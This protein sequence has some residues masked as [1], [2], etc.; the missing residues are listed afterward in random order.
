M[1]SQRSS[2]KGARSPGSKTGGSK[3]PVSKAPSQRQLRVGEELRHALARI[4]ARDE[5]RD[6]VLVG[7][8]LT[9]TEVRVSPDLKNAT[10]FVVPLGGDG[11]REVLKVLNRAG[12]F[13][14]SQMSREVDL[15]HTPKLSFQA[16]HSFDEAAKIN[17]LLQNPRV[18]RDV[19]A[20][21]LEDGAEEADQEEAPAAE[22]PEDGR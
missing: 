18:L 21:T 7:V 9:V 20:P 5:L 2:A 1:G 19:E 6:P 8:S 16:D 11:S 15:R 14:R 22:R 13:L 10:A 12:P 17:A 4:L 3:A